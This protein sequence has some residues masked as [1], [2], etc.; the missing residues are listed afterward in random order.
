MQI[1]FLGVLDEHFKMA[2]LRL[3]REVETGRGPVDFTVTGDRRVR[4][5]VEMKRLSNTDFWHGLKTQTPTY[6]QAQEARSAIFLA[7]MDLDTPAARKRW[8]TMQEAAAA[9]RAATGLRIEVERI[10]VLPKPSA[11][12]A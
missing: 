9:V 5:L 2:G 12:K 11:S 6:V 3:D 1:L 7:V 4:V 10:D 8:E